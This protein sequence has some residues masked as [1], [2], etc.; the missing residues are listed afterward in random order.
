MA[1]MFDLKRCPEAFNLKVGES[2]DLSPNKDK[3]IVKKMLTQGKGGE[4]PNEG[5]KVFYKYTAYLGDK[6]I[7]EYIFDSTEK[8]GKPFEYECLKGK[9]IRG[10]ELAV[11]TMKPGERSLIFIKP[12]YGFGKSVPPSVPLDTDILFDIEI[13]KVE[14]ADISSEQDKSVLKKVL[15]RG[16]GLLH[17]SNGCPVEL[18]IKGKCGKRVFMDK[19]V[20]FKMGEGSS[21][22]HGLP[23]FIERYLKHWKTGEEARVF[24]AARQAFGQEGCEKYDIGPNKDLTFWINMKQIER[25]K[26]YWE[27]DYKEKMDKSVEY[28]EIGEK[29]FKGGEYELATTIYEKMLE[30][31]QDDLEGEDE[32]RRRDLVVFGNLRL[33]KAYLKVEKNSKARDC[34][35]KALTFDENNLKAYLRRG[36]AN[37]ADGEYETAK[38]DFQ[39]VLEIEPQNKPAKDQIDKC[40]IKMD[41]KANSDIELARKMMSS[42]GKQV[43]G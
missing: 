9:V 10:F 24:F 38:K 40:I 16:K 4:Y 13:I 28:K 6:M 5:D 1:E 27:M 41:E 18:H 22:E 39:K 25:V 3:G 34:C 36:M 23:P 17:P 33:A 30:Y 19:D 14:C 15:V 21:E 31:V 8:D 43:T 29:H 2:A 11:L 26:E 7:K 37:F 12:E 35:D 32:E 42:I 20:K